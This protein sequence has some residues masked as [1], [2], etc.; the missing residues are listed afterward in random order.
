MLKILFFSF[1]IDLGLIINE[2]I[3]FI[4]IILF[5]KKNPPLGRVII[6]I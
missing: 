2:Y 3:F 6:Y 5:N 4:E 1:L